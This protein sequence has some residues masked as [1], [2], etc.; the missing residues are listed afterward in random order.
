[1]PPKLTGM[2]RYTAGFR[3]QMALYHL[4]IGVEGCQNMKLFFFRKEGIDMCLDPAIIL[5]VMIT[6]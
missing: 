3:C 5:I 4:M 2:Y 1:M 6:K